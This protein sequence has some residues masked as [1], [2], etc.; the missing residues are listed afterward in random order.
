MKFIRQL[1]EQSRQSSFAEVKWTPGQ[2]VPHP[3]RDI[4]MNWLDGRANLEQAAVVDY[5]P[6]A[7]WMKV[8]FPRLDPAKF[9]LR[10]IT[11]E[12][13][14]AVFK[15]T[16]GKLLPYTIPRLEKRFEAEEFVESLGYRMIVDWTKA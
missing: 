11:P 16:S 6:T 7:A 1:K 14:V 10:E 3:H 4:L 5:Q 13:Y 12:E 9:A 2:G 8:E 15:H